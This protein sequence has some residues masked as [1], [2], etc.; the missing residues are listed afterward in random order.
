M[1]VKTGVKIRF[2]P[3]FQKEALKLG[4]SILPPIVQQISAASQKRSPVEFGLNKR[5][6]VERQHTETKWDL[7]TE[8]GYGGWLHEGTRRNKF[9][10]RPYM[11]GGAEFVGRHTRTVK[12]AKELD[13]PFPDPGERL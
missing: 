5:S 7:H 11:R 8:S 6:H 10:R 13:R 3:S 1:A 4:L 2:N 9:R 12:D